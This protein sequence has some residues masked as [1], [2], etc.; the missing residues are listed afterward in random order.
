MS[1]RAALLAAVQ[2]DFPT[3]NTREIT[4]E[5][6]RDFLDDYIDSV[7][8]PDTDGTPPT[9]S[10]TT[11][12]FGTV[13]IVGT[14]SR[15]YT[16]PI[17]SAIIART[18]AAQTFTGTQ[19]FSAI[20]SPAATDLTISSA[21]GAGNQNIVFAPSGTGRLY[22]A[23]ADATQIYLGRYLWDDATTTDNAVLQM[24]T[25]GDD[26]GSNSFFRMD[27]SRGTIS[28][29]SAVQSGD[30]IF[31][32]SGRGYGTSYSAH[33]NVSFEAYAAGTFTGSSLPTAFRWLNTPS[34]ST[35]KL[36][37][38]SLLN[39]GDLSL[40]TPGG[41]GETAPERGFHTFGSASR[42]FTAD[43]YSATENS[44]VILRRARGSYG[45]GSAVQT[46]DNLGFFGV[47]GY[48][49]G[50]AFSTG[51]RAG[52]GLYAAENWTAVANGSYAIIKT[53]PVGST[54]LTDAVTIS[55]AQNVTFAGTLTFSGTSSITSASGQALVLAT[56]TS[57]TALTIASADNAVALRSNAVG[58]G[59]GNG[60]SMTDTRTGF[61]AAVGPGIRFRGIINSGLTETTYATIRGARESGTENVQDGALAFYTNSGGTLGQRLLI[62]SAGI[63]TSNNTTDASAL[64]A[65]SFV[66][67][68]GLSVAKA[69]FNGSFI[70]GAVIATP[71]APAAS[72]GRLYFDTSGGKV[73]LMALFP[74]GAAQL[75][76]TEP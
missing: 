49:S 7:W 44:Q 3:N 23:Y 69:Q 57:G 30:Y 25:A 48:H 72:N 36:V 34:G 41:S 19:A 24:R 65:A 6:L 13:Q 28:S 70:N 47:R 63:I 8:I 64:G 12:T 22:T 46:N 59:F 51:A 53:T 10:G 71:S 75:V 55:S 61:A 2:A 42:V 9:Y 32:V 37:Y 40:G 73:R 76:A 20:T 56:G 5:V 17:T 67:S 39:N 14:A 11:L 45:S 27:R 4:A 60:L 31:T 50:G 62:S 58:D 18:D 54:T 74:T 66:M 43:T 35:T 16:M 21:G 38:L 33:S 26:A 52:L 15:V 1:T 68:G 29:P